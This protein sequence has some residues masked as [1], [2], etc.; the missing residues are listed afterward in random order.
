MKWIDKIFKRKSVEEKKPDYPDHVNGIDDFVELP[1]ERGWEME[2]AL[3]DAVIKPPS[4]PP[5]RIISEDVKLKKKKKT[6]TKKR[7][8]KKMP[9][10][11]IVYEYYSCEC[12]DWKN[13]MP[14]IVQQQTYASQRGNMPYTGK[15]FVYCP[16]CG[17]KRY[18]SNR[19]KKAS[20]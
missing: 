15:N 6:T 19:G 13:F 8:T 7:S 14:Q 11:E 12:E 4:P 2:P 10:P 17:W 1:E 16:W 9:L 3:E 20:K 5:K 18:R